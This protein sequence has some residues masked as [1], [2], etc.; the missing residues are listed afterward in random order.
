MNEQE[1]KRS[2]NERVL[3]VDHET[4]TPLVFSIYRG[5]GIQCNKSYSW[6]SRLIFD[7][8]NSS[9]LTTMN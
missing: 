4:F 8:R 3:Q 1:K 6:L 2:N 7:K 9:K 5:M